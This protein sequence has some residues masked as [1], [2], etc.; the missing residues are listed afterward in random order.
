MKNTRRPPDPTNPPNVDITEEIAHGEYSNLIMIAHSTEEFILDFIRIMP[1][2]E[3]AQVKSRIIIAPSHAKRFL[4]ALRDNISRYEKAYGQIVE[5]GT[6][7]GS[8]QFG[9]GAVGEA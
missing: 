1:G 6:L 5:R 9:A 8:I 4:R 3:S 2:L 7:D